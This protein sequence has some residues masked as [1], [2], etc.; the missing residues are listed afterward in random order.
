MEEVGRVS[1]VEV[2]FSAMSVGMVISV[3]DPVEFLLCVER[4]AVVWVLG[5]L[6]VRVRKGLLSLVE[7]DGD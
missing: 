6:L 2:A 1:V 4:T 3:V 5:N 7:A